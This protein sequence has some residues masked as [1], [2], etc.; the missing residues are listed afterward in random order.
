MNTGGDVTAGGFD[1]GHG[2]SGAID[3]PLDTALSRRTLTVSG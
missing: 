2:L 3:C 1:P